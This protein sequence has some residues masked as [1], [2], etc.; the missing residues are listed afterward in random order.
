MRILILL[1][2]IACPAAAP[3]QSAAGQA[4]AVDGDLLE[5]GGV[6][7]RLFGVDA[8]EARQSCER[9]GQSWQCGQE[10][11]ALLGD[12]V[13]RGSV[14]C[15]Q[16]DVD[17][18]GQPVAICTVGRID[19]SDAMARAGMAVPLTDISEAYVQGAETARLHNLGIWAGTFEQ[20]NEFRSQNASSEPRERPRAIVQER[21]SISRNVPQAAVYR[22]C[23]AARAAGAAP[24]YRGQPGYRPQMDGDGD[25][26][27][28]EPY[29]RR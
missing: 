29:R 9:G 13:Q 22:N 24:L 5:V 17:A 26:I 10:A 16:Q 3:A 15:E 23:D 27:A 20:P 21:V 25:G 28:C 6:R 14:R 8:P 11:A 19:L 7:V 12:L 4:I 2:L 18:D 1:A